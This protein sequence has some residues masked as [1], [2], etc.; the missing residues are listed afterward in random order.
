MEYIPSIYYSVSS[1][2]GKIQ[3]KIY[4]FNEN[5]INNDEYLIYDISNEYPDINSLLSKLFN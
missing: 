2:E 3:K 4:L 1:L 5:K